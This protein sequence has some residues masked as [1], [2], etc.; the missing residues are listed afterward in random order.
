MSLRPLVVCIG[1]GNPSLRL[2]AKAHRGDVDPPPSASVHKD[3]EL[4]PPPI[5][6]A[7]GAGNILHRLVLV[8]TVGGELLLPPCA[9]VQRGDI[10]CTVSKRTRAGKLSLHPTLVCTLAGNLSFLYAH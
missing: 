3:W 8:C 6:K 1:A 9:S 2:Y 10:I 7:H 4:V 5:A